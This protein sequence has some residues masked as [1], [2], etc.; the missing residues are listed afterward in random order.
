MWEGPRGLRG[1]LGGSKWSQVILE[2]SRGLS[3]GVKDPRKALGGSRGYQRA[4]R[5]P[6]GLQTALPEIPE[7]LWGGPRRFKGAL[8]GT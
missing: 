1:V 6:R 2:G 8:G 5:C 3:G 4:L 7:R